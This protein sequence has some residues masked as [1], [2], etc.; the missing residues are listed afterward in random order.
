MNFLKIMKLV[1]ETIEKTSDLDQVEFMS[2]T[3]ML[4]EEWC[5]KTG[6]NVVE[7]QEHALE[8]T[9]AVNKALG[10]Y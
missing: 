8:T 1:K 10:K 7:Y 4:I 2:F 5:K 6:V 3:C 9:K